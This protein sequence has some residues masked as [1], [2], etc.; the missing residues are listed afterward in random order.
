[1]ME[2]RYRI[3]VN[4]KDFGPYG[5]T[6]VRGGSIYSSPENTYSALR[7]ER[8]LRT[9]AGENNS[10]KDLGVRIMLSAPATFVVNSKVQELSFQETKSEEKDYITPIIIIILS[11]V[12]LFIFIISAHSKKVLQDK[13]KASEKEKEIKKSEFE[14]IIKKTKEDSLIKQTVLM[15]KLEESQQDSYIKQEELKNKLET[16]KKQNSIKQKDLIAKIEEIKK[17]NELILKNKERKTEKKRKPKIFSPSFCFSEKVFK[18]KISGIP[19]NSRVNIS[20]NSNVNFEGGICAIANEEGKT[21]FLIKVKQEYIGEYL[22]PFEIK[23]F[24]D[25]AYLCTLYSKKILVKKTTTKEYKYSPSTREELL[26][27][28]KKDYIKLDEISTKKIVDMHQLFLFSKR[29]DFSG[30]NTWDVSNVENMSHM[31]MGQKHFNEDISSWMPKKLKTA[32]CM[33]LNASSF[34]KDIESWQLPSS[35]CMTKMF[36]GTALEGAEPSWFLRK[37]E[38]LITTQ[39]L[40]DKI[41]SLSSDQVDNLIYILCN[42]TGVITRE[43]LYNDFK[44]R[45]GYFNNILDYFRHRF[46]TLITDKLIAKEISKLS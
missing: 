7:V 36:E 9:Q 11:A 31:F 27:L 26:E 6:V 32:N 33:F 28:I 14:K 16:E 18:I 45:G 23:V 2:E 5:G 37:E 19:T 8:S 44:K 38:K 12:C 22:E 17:E 24:K 3:R 41:E 35:V 1:M 15:N 25:D 40:E 39:D 10:S 4:G 20:K 42:D 21:E 29:N 46:P 43:R 34:N 13:L 30:I